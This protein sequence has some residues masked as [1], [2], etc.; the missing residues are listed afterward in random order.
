MEILNLFQKNWVHLLKILKNKFKKLRVVFNHIFIISES[1]FSIDD[2]VILLNIKLVIIL[3]KVVVLIVN[4]SFDDKGHVAERN[5]D[6]VSKIQPT[7]SFIIK[8]IPLMISKCL[9]L[10]HFFLALIVYIFYIIAS[11]S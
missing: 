2:I 4:F 7:M 9:S 3:L 1:S 8:S 6:V 11:Q 5:T 10:S